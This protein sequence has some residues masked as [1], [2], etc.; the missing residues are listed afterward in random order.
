MLKPL[1]HPKGADRTRAPSSCDKDRQGQ[2]KG[3]CSQ[4]QRAGMAG[5]PSHRDHSPLPQNSNTHHESPGA[6][7]D[8]WESSG[9][10][11]AVSG[12]TAV[13]NH[14]ALIYGCSSPAHDPPGRSVNPPAAA[15]LPPA[16]M[17]SGLIHGAH[18]STPH[19]WAA[20]PGADKYSSGTNICI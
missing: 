11:G 9:R 3:N 17:E 19:C 5:S 2:D 8:G 20:F 7:G 12:G 10:P 6:A 13:Q 14:W 1:Q 4:C 16:W 18:C 15:V